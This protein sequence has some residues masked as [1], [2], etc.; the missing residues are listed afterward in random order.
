MDCNAKCHRKAIVP[1][2]SHFL[3]H[4][5][6]QGNVFEV[7]SRTGICYAS[8][9]TVNDLTGSIGSVNKKEN[10]AAEVWKRS[11]SISEEQQHVTYLYL[12]QVK[13]A[14]M[15]NALYSEHAKRRIG[16]CT[17]V[18]TRSS[19]SCLRSYFIPLRLHWESCSC[20]LRV[21]LS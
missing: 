21:E 13:S 18:K 4:V 19:Q 20:S 17:S 6:S 12:E 8:R 5:H 15:N 2:D 1:Q 14:M 11:A 9:S 7:V 16:S 10:V 3:P